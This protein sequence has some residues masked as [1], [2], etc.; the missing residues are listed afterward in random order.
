MKLS[1]RLFCRF[2]GP[3]SL[4]ASADPPE[5]GSHVSTG[6]KAPQ[7]DAPPWSG[8]DAHRA[9]RV[10]RRS[11]GTDG[12]HGGSDAPR[13]SAAIVVLGLAAACR[14]APDPATIVASGHVEATDVR[15][16]TKIP[17]RLESFA[18][19]EGDRVLEGQVLAQVDT[20]DLR[21]SM[22][23]VRAE[24]DQAAAELA[25][26]KAGARREDIGELEAQIQSIRAD[27]D[28]AQ[29]DLDRMQALLD[30]GS[31]TT[32][33]RDDALA[34]R[35]S[36]AGHLAAARQALARAR[37]GSRSEEIDAAR[38]RLDAADARLA[39]IAKQ[40]ADATITSPVSGIVT[41][42]VAERGELLPAGSPISIVTDLDRPWLT[43][44]VGGPDLGR[45]RIGQDARVVTDDGQVR[46]GRVSFISSTA[47][48]TP[49]NVQTREERVK[50]VYEVRVALENADGLFKPG[51]P[52]EA[53][54]RAADP[55]GAIP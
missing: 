22:A 5:Q 35:D 37:A 26:R 43:V 32:K 48:F 20:S 13:L 49:K 15:I 31:G 11:A 47:E 10:A 52:A 34:R 36:L 9:R 54:L 42:K 46:T 3:D 39:I 1:D 12:R 51:M 45:V 29:K 7:R 19:A 21:L 41:E 38:A 53:R 8:G 16:S 27:L 25:L 33:A 2:L 17:G 28:A 55:V 18:V 44:Y 4:H 50:L 14:N 24:R 30:R 40:I 6:S 23:Q